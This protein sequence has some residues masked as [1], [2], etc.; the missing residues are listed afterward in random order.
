MRIKPASRTVISNPEP[1]VKSPV[2]GGLA[3][4]VATGAAVA[5]GDV[6]AGVGVGSADSTSIHEPPEVSRFVLRGA[7]ET[8]RL[9]LAVSFEIRWIPTLFVP[10][11]AC[12]DVV[13]MKHTVCS[14]TNAP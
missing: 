12:L 3:V 5:V 4:G 11:M 13:N 7:G 10:L 2:A 14:V 9:V 1:G 6:S 8:I